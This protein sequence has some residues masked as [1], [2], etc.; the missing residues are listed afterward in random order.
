ME[1]AA[2]IVWIYPHQ[3]PRSAW[4]KHGEIAV[5]D[6]SPH[7]PLRDPQPIRHVPDGEKL[8]A[9]QTALP[10]AAALCFAGRASRR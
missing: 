4:S 2:E 3:P 10:P 9:H 1:K 8:R 5:G 7:R 6:P